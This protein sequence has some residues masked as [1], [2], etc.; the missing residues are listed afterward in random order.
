MLHCVTLRCPFCNEQQTLW[1]AHD[2]IGEMVTDC[3]VCCRPWQLVVWVDTEGQLHARAG[4][5]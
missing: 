4:R 3:E 2:D 1:L 5:E